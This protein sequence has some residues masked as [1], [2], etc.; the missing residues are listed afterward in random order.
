MEKFI[1]L[2]NIEKFI[3]WVL[4]KGVL[5]HWKCIVEYS[6][7]VLLPTLTKHADLSDLPQTAARNYTDASMLAAFE[8]RGASAFIQSLIASSH[9]L[10]IYK[11]DQLQLLIADEYHPDCFSCSREFYEQHDQ[12]W[13]RLKLA[14]G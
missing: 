4:G 5:C 2:T 7:P 3:K 12:E 6:D 10:W 14:R 11:E 1:E 13:R 9:V 8:P